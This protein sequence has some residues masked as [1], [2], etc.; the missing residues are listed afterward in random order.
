MSERGP[1]GTVCSRGCSPQGKDRLAATVSRGPGGTAQLG[2][3]SMSP[4]VLSATR[5]TAGLFMAC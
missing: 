3:G 2:A 4:T 1:P 5:F